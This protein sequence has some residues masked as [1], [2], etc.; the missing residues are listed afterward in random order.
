MIYNR[1]FYPASSGIS[2]VAA[3]GRI[4]DYDYEYDYDYE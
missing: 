1:S 4:K 2:L 3:K